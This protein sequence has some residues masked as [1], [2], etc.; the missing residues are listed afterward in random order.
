M[1]IDSVDGMINAPAAPITARHAISCHIAVD[2]D[3][4]AGADEEQHQPELQRA[5]APEAVA[6]RA[7]R[8]QQAGEH[9]RVARDDPLQ[10]RLGRVELARERRDRDVEARVADEDDQQAEA[11]HRE[12]PPAPVVQR[13]RP[14]LGG[15]WWLGGHPDG[16][17]SEAWTVGSK[18]NAGSGYATI[19]G[20]MRSASKRSR[21]APMTDVTARPMRSDARRNRERVLA[22][23]EDVFSEMGLRAQVEEVARRAGVGVGTVCRHFPTK[24]ALVEAVLEAM[25]ESLLARRAAARWSSPIPARRS[26]RSSSRSRSSRPAT[27]RSP[28][29]WRPRSTC[30][31]RRNR[32]ATRCAAAIGELVD[33]RAGRGRDPRRHRSGRRRDAVLRRRARDRA[34]GRPAARAAQALRRASS[35]TGCARSRRATLPGRPLDF[36]QLQQLKKPRPQ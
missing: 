21:E 8:E 10:L 2:S 7:G 18:W 3:A 29:R 6:E 20:I 28:S 1:M 15:R 23:A 32:C 25:Y 9:E 33:P 11:Q 26:R 4:S 5:L 14:R 27:A 30:P 17:T 19:I 16:E 13:S 22:A 34:R 12:R 24:Q 31:R 36:A 35:S